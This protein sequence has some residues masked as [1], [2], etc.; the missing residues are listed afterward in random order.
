[1]QLL[2]SDSACNQEV[3]NVLE[4]YKNYVHLQH[5]N[6]AYQEVVEVQNVLEIHKNNEHSVQKL[7]LSRP[8]N[9]STNVLDDFFETLM[10]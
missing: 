3:V 1:M 5:Y 7:N 6:N 10:V 2:N 8:F 9:G 4:I